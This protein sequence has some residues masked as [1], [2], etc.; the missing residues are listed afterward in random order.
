[1]TTVKKMARPAGKPT[2]KI[3]DGIFADGK[4]I[5]A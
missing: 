2:I 1:M 4:T 5:S 3:R